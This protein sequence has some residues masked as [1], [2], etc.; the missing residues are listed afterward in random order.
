[1][2]LTLR[3]GALTL[4]T[5]DTLL[6]FSWGMGLLSLYRLAFPTGAHR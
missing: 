3:I 2:R 5:P 4:T 1:V 6:R